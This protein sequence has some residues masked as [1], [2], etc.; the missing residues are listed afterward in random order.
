M[1]SKK[2]T[3]AERFAKLGENLKKDGR[4]QIDEAK[5]QLSEQIF[6][7]MENKGI[8]ESELSR[9]LDVSRAYINKVLQGDTNFTIETLVKIGIALDCEFKF[10]FVEKPSILLMRKLSTSKKSLSANLIT[11]RL[12]LVTSQTDFM[13]SR[14]LNIKLLSTFHLLKCNFK[15][16]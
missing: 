14:I 1:S 3:A 10:S 7:T 13:I 11:F 15:G 9:R 8:S 6:Q 5:L 2:L 4:L 16:N 12:P